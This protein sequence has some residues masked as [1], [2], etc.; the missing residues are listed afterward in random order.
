[1]GALWRQGSYIKIVA[2]RKVILAAF[3]LGAAGAGGQTVGVRHT[4]VVRVPERSAVA[5][6]SS[7][8]SPGT[9]DLAG[10]RLPHIAKM[11]AGSPAAASVSL[12]GS[13]PTASPAESFALNGNL[14][15]VC[16]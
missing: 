6:R 10:A 11:A 7:A 4:Q 12:L 8:I 5:G 9:A 14:A 15:Y 13:V 1:M 3:L 2:W 16:D